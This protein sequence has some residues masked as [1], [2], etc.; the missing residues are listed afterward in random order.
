MRI[1]VIGGGHGCYAAAADLSEQGH[2]VRLWRRSVADFGPVLKD[3]ALTLIDAARGSRAVPLALVTADIAAALEGAELI[4]SLLPATAQMET[5]SRLA[6]HLTDGDVVFLA[7]GTFG[8]YAMT[9]ELR[10]LGNDADVAFADAGT[11]P[12]LA[13]KHGAGAIAITARATRLPTG[14]FPARRADDAF[15]RLC[16]AYPAIERRADALD[17]ALMNA[18]PV[19]HPPLILLN[20]G[21]LQHFERWDIHTEGTQPFIRAVTDA[22]DAERIAVR[23]AMGYGPPHFPLADHYD[24]EREEWMYGQIAHVDLQDSGDWRERID[25]STHRYMREDVALGLAFLVSVARYAGVPCPTAE[26]LLN[27]SAAGLGEA[28]Y[29]RGRTLENLGLAGLTRQELQALLHDGLA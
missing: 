3:Q 7:P 29:D 21:P 22:L 23:V 27:L 16:A 10:R 25:L 4:L 8:S 26:A 14:V 15:A 12:Y 5:A 11:L 24:P 9:R 13:R 17:G 18:G 2:E 28:L 20:A 19:I 1:A 6:P